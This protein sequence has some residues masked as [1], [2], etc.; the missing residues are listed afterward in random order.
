MVVAAP[1]SSLTALHGHTPSDE[2][3]TLGVHR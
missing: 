3:T 1:A 2:L